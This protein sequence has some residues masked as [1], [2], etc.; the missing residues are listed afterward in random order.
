MK[1]RNCQTRSSTGINSNSGSLLLLLYI[2]YLHVSIHVTNVSE[3]FLSFLDDTH[4]ILCS[5]SHSWA[6]ILACSWTQ[7]AQL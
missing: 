2:A 4:Y 3:F 1:S 7:F 5:H 6:Y